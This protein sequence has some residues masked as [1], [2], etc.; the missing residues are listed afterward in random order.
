MD[1]SEQE[2]RFYQVRNIKSETII[3]E[4]HL[5]KNNGCIL[6]DFTFRIGDMADHRKEYIRNKLHCE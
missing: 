1:A 3:T 6:R 5:E 4:I 2:K